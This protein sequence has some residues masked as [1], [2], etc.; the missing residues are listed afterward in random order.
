MLVPVVHSGSAFTV[1][2]LVVT[3]E[4]AAEV[5]DVA[6]PALSPIELAPLL[7]GGVASTKADAGNPPR[8]CASAA[9]RAYGTLSSRTR[10]CSSPPLIRTPS[11]RA[12]PV[13]NRSS[14][15]PLELE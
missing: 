13:L 2:P 10:G 11:Q 12:S 5:A 6:V 9:F 7:D 3:S 1:P 14:G 4:L 15:K 8:V